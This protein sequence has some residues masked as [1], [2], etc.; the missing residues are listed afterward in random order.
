[1]SPIAIAGTDGV[2]LAAYDLGGSG[3]PA[4]LVHG[5]GL[6]A[7]SLRPLARCLAGDF[8]CRALDL[9]A[10][11]A[12]SA[13]AMF[14]WDGFVDDV[15]DAAAT[16]GLHHPVAFGH[17]LGATAILGAEAAN[18]GT[19]RQIFCYEPILFSPALPELP[20][21]AIASSTRHR[22]AVFASRAEA[23]EHFRERPP[24]AAWDP[25]ALAGYLEG[26][27]VDLADGS[28]GLACAPEDE[29]C[30]Y[31]AA[32]H[33]DVYGHLG[34]VACPVTIARGSASQVLSEDGAGG[35]AARLAAGSL[36]EFAGLDHFGPYT[37]PSLVAAAVL[38]AVDAAGA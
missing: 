38:S 10:H 24:F 12:S 33:C 5:A 37:D 26:G 34:A 25:G 4:L 1:M 13:P 3:R 32:R 29:A 30:I 7:L 11:G 14:N 19:F 15:L 2:T 27:L 28:V 6:N 8:A 20:D 18:P 36:A 35:I 22:R 9:R 17:S 31:E 16:L 23:A 21:E